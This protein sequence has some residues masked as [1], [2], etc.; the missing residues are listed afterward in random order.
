PASRYR[1]SAP[2]ESRGISL[3]NAPSRELRRRWLAAH[4]EPKRMLLSSVFETLTLRLHQTVLPRDRCRSGCRRHH[5]DG[6]WDSSPDTTTTVFVCRKAFL[7]A[8]AS[9]PVVAAEHATGSR[10]HLLHR[11]RA[12]L[13]AFRRAH[14]RTRKCPCAGRRFGLSPVPATYRT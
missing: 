3:E 6:S 10:Q 2:T 1:V 13:P 4:S 9:S 8:A 14:N 7:R 5:G 12:C 11:R